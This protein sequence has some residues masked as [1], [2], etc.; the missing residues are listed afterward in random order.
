MLKIHLLILNIRFFRASK[1]TYTIGELA[2]PVCS[3]LYDT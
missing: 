2:T 1:D 3:T